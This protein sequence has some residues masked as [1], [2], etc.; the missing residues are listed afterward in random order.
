MEYSTLSRTE[1]LNTCRATSVIARTSAETPALALPHLLHEEILE[2]VANRVERDQMSA[3]RRRPGDRGVRRHRRGKHHVIAIRA[4]H[5]RRPAKFDQGA[6]ALV[7]QRADDQL[8][9]A[10]TERSEKHTSELQS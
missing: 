7:R 8:P 9:A 4:D 6:R 1:S 5:L 3:G 10:D 2:G